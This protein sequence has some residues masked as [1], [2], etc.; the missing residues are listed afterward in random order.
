MAYSRVCVQRR[1]HRSILPTHADMQYA[2]RPSTS[3][4]SALVF[5]LAGPLVLGIAVT[6]SAQ[7]VRP[8]DTL[9]FP[10]ATLVG[11]ALRNNLDLRAAE[12]SPRLAGADLLAARGVFDRSLTLAT[13]NDVSSLDVFGTSSRSSRS[14]IESTATLA[15]TVPTGTQ[16]ALSLGNSR[17]SSDPFTASSSQP[18]Q[19]SHASSV[20][21]T[22]T[23]PLLR[24]MGRAGAYGA[25][26][27]AAVSVDASRSRYERNAD[28]TVALVERGYWALRRAESN[29]IV[30]RQAVSAARAIYD[31]NVALQTRDVATQLDVLT[32]ER[33]L[34]TREAQLLD[35][36]R[37]RVDAA[38]RLLYLVYGE[39]AKDSVRAQGARVYTL[40]DSVVI[41]PVPDVAAAEA[42]AFAQRG[43]IIATS[44]DVEAGRLRSA[45]SRSL[46][47]PVLDLIA[48]YAYGGIAPTSTFVQFGDTGDRRSSTFSFGLTTS[49]FQRNDAARAAD[50][51]AQSALEL[52]RLSQRAVENAVH[53]EVSTAVRALA[54][55]RE[56]YARARDV[57]RLAA[58]EYALAL[59]GS[60]LGLVSTF[61]L[62]Q[63]QDALS[64]GGQLVAQARF[65]LED[66]GSQYRLAIGGSRLGYPRP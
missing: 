43:D 19:T 16:L 23:Q 4:R 18:F 55:G 36:A 27:A 1:K 30:A 10:L 31:R 57:E 53:A 50:E 54:T 11:T 62:L 15:G 21:L 24:G 17:L 51:R 28:V 5:R 44:R 64:Q 63:Y 26:D 61:Q 38:E 25:V 49:L 42:I 41:P 59:E 13:A 52:A 29:E 2:S 48:S 8:T 12:L 3:S 34:A 47:L 6:V 7:D 35:A 20:G 39:E 60:R 9:R 37:E 45:Q 46:R 58:R 33:G 66:A 14:F 65:A 32:S 22:L 56:R 40:R